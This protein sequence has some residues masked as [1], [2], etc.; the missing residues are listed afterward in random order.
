MAGND[1][2]RGRALEEMRQGG[3]EG[4]LANAGLKSAQGVRRVEMKKVQHPVL[5]RLARIA[6]CARARCHAS[7]ACRAIIAIPNRKHLIRDLTLLAAA[8]AVLVYL[9]YLMEHLL[10]HPDSIS[11]PNFSMMV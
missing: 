4:C 1:A 9:G 10:A 11:L 8:G 7:R 3:N 6:A 5:S 2:A